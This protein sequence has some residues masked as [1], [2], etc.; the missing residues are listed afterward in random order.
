MLYTIIIYFM[1]HLMGM[2]C[3][4][5]HLYVHVINSLQSSSKASFIKNPL[6]LQ[7]LIMEESAD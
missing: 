4:K 3:T 6:H 1:I 2:N 5:V 7:A